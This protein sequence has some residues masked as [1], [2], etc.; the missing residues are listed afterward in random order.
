MVHCV[1]DFTLHDFFE[2]FEV[3]DKAGAGI[4][5]AL[6]RD[7]EGVIVTVTMRVIALTENAAILLGGKCGVVVE[8]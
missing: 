1:E 2:L 5:L 8:V 3:D 7:F 6:H 4:D